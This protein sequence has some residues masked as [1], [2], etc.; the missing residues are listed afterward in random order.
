MATNVKLEK[1]LRDRLKLLKTTDSITHIISCPF[2]DKTGVAAAKAIADKYEDHET[3]FCYYPNEDCPQS[4]DVGW[5]ETWMDIADNVFETGG[6]A[7][8][9]H[10]TDGKGKFACEALG[11]G[12]LDG[13]AQ[14]GEVKYAKKLGCKIEFV[15]YAGA[16]AAAVPP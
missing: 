12:S 9:V 16:A 11:P 8:I 4:L 3:E 10:R 15:G 1:M 6:T 14:S 2:D 7:F 5:L 13:Q